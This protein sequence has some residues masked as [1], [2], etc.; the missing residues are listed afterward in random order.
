[1]DQTEIM[2]WTSL[3]LELI[4]LF[5]LIFGVAAAKGMKDV[6]GHYRLLALATA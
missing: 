4:V 1:M 6:K 5:L 3:L 2:R